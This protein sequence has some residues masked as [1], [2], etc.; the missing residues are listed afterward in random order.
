VL[1]TPAIPTEP[2]DLIAHLLRSYSNQKI[3]FV[4]H[5]KTRL[6]CAQLKQALCRLAR[7]QPILGCRLSTDNRK[8]TWQTDLCRA[9]VVAQAK[10]T[11]G[12]LSAAIDELIEAYSV[13]D[14]AIDVC[15]IRD[16][17]ADSLLVCLDH[18]VTDAAGAKE[19]CYQLADNYT[20]AESEICAHKSLPTRRARSLR[21]ITRRLSFTRKIRALANARIPGGK[22]QFPPRSDS[23][24]GRIG[25]VFRHLQPGSLAAIKRRIAGTPVTLNDVLTGA[26]LL[27]PG[28]TELAGTNRP[29]PV[30]FMVDL[31][32]YLPEG[33]RGLIANLSGVEHVWIARRA[34]DGL[35]DVIQSAHNA[36]E[37][38]KRR[39]P[40][41]GTAM[42]TEIAMRCGMIGLP[43]LISTSLHRTLRTGMANPIFSNFGVIDEHRLIFGNTP[44]SHAFMLGPCLRTPGI[45]LVAS[46]YRGRLT[47]STGG[48]SGFSAA[49]H[50]EDMLEGLCS[51]LHG[52]ARRGFES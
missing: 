7:Q 23:E 26:F 21:L 39:D 38:I 9:P 42:L 50:T 24:N 12:V 28:I 30:Q 22:W 11:T 52:L 13:G 27:A 4:V 29:M 46:A 2:L 8:P 41:L 35:G 31:R 33:Q 49:F 25:Y 44:I 17:D 34:D 15:V 1:P 6:K 3:F 32:R 20:Q 10:N 40:G 45:M 5:F 51:H 47:L 48:G 19:I 43:K 18:A 37:K 36:L 16:A 14:N